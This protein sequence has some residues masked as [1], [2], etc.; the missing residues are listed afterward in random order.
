LIDYLIS[1]EK[2]ER[3]IS[4]RITFGFSKINNIETKKQFTI[5]SCIKEWY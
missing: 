2:K 5:Y 4:K 3:I 1:K